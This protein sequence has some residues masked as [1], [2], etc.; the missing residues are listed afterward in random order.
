MGHQKW[1][2]FKILVDLLIRLNTTRPLQTLVQK[3]LNRL[4]NI[5]FFIVDFN[6]FGAAPSRLWAE[7]NKLMKLTIIIYPYKMISDPEKMRYHNV[8]SFITPQRG[9]YY[10]KRA[11]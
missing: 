10:G 8:P 2:R 11:A 1:T 7:F 5:R 9:S 4:Q 3:D 6:I